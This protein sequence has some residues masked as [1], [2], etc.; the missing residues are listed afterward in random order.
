MTKRSLLACCAAGLLIASCTAN[1]HDDA[2]ESIHTESR[3]SHS[4][5]HDGFTDVFRVADDEWSSSGANP[6]FILEPGYF[7][8]L[9]GQDEGEDVRLTITVLDETKTVAGVETR[10]VE[11]REEAGGALIEVSRNYFA[12][13]RTTNSVY[14]FG[15]DVDIYADGKVANH[16]GAWV[17]GP[18][19]RFG[20]MMPGTPL[21]GARYYQEMAPGVAMDR[22]EIVSLEETLTTPLGTF[23]HCLKVIE[24]TP[25]EP[26]RSP[27]HYAPGI[28]LIQDDNLELTKYGRVE[29]P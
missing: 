10:V 22:A 21:V 2:K 4:K 26:G 27:K 7:L 9:E 3:A 11:E 8:V 20:L 28:G 24:S 1:G 18:T 25:L 14:Y 29:K 5:P 6:Y 12:I 23:E 15:E 16:G 13:S 19:A 17:A